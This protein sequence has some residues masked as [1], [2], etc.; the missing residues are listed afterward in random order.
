MAW[1]IG[2]DIGGTFTDVAIVDD[3]SGRIGVAK[4]LT[5]PRDFAD[6]VLA[7]LDTAMRRYGIEASDVTLL[8]HATT[9]VTNALLEEKG[10]RA[11]MIATAG[12]RDVIELRRSS[13]PDLY[14]LFQDAPTT[15][16]PRHRRLEIVERV[17]ADGRVVIPMAEADIDRLVAAVQ[18]VA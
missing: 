18:A 14:D 15:L 10:A 4:M 9:V 5:T 11:V 6:G 1:R 16:I 12:F 8:A 13:R 3:V 2:V 17:G 7:A